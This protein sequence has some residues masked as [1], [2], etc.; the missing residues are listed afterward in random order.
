MAKAIKSAGRRQP[1]ATRRNPIPLWLVFGGAVVLLITAFFALPRKPAAPYTP[2]VTGAPSLQTDQDQVE[3][4]DVKLGT[5][6]HVSFQLKNVG[7]QPLQFSEL[8]YVEVVEG[9]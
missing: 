7:D 9:C 8:P 3:L 4:G 5:T 6:V 2:V 1:A